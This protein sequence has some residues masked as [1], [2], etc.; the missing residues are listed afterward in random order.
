MLRETKPYY[1]ASFTTT[2]NQGGSINSLK[3][4]PLVYG[5]CWCPQISIPK[6]FMVD[7]KNFLLSISDIPQKFVNKTKTT[8]FSGKFISSPFKIRSIWC[9]I[10]SAFH[11]SMCRRN[12]LF[13]SY[14]VLFGYS[15]FSKR[16]A[17][18]CWLANNY[19]FH[20]G[21]MSLG[22]VFQCCVAQNSG[23]LGRVEM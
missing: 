11:S 3:K 14:S 7:V 8:S 18:D 9:T 13:S 23:L 20:K 2:Q 6:R 1:Q 22:T 12:G 5:L 4:F 19:P 16:H 15:S 17:V 21:F 10:M